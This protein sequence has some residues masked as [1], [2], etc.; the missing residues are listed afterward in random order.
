[1]ARLNLTIPDPL[2]E[3]LERLRDRVNVSKVCAIA[4]TKELDMLEGN[5]TT[6][7]NPK[8]RRMIERLQGVKNRRDRWFQRGYEDGED[9]AAERAEPH[10][11]RFVL[12]EW[13]FDEEETYNLGDV[14]WPESFDRRAA[15]RRWV[16]ADVAAHDLPA[17]DLP[18]APSEFEE[19]VLSKSDQDAYLRGFS[20]AIEE[21]W[22][23]AG[24]AL[25]W[26][27][28]EE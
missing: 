14:E 7:A 6:A 4:L 24:S 5:M 2:Y 26:L 8:A 23:A 16:S 17:H 3:R 15:I 18:P 27:T 1:M 21:M 10:E 28:E 25:R 12:N 13:D 19:S 9:W 22:K 11:L 20:D